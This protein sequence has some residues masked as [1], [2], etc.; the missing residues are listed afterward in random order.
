MVKVEMVHCSLASS[1]SK[2]LK[3]KCM[4]YF[5]PAGGLILLP[6]SPKKPYGKV[7]TTWLNGIIST[8]SNVVPNWRSFPKWP[9][10]IHFRNYFC[11]MKVLLAWGDLA[12]WIAARPHKGCASLWSCGW[13]SADTQRITT[14]VRE[15]N[16]PWIIFT[17]ATC[18]AWIVSVF[19][20]SSHTHRQT[21]AKCT[22]VHNAS[23][24]GSV[25]VCRVLFCSPG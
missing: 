18:L 16:K 19:T 2:W 7:L 1:P 5:W 21:G 24:N 9:V 17:T 4:N 6:E 22:R 8:D 13:G 23:Q 3:S 25:S 10:S 11:I 14:P 12:F 20:N 15:I